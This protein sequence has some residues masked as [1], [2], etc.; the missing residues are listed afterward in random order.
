MTHITPAQARRA[1]NAIAMDTISGALCVRHVTPY[2]TLT[3]FIQ[4]YEQM[5][6]ALKPFAT[7]GKI[8]DGPFGPA[9][10]A[11]DNMAFSSGCAW[12]ENGE[13]KTLTWGNFRR[14]AA[15]TKGE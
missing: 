15:A 5:E 1:M 10:F 7:V 2:D 11:E 6:A 8:I 13:S 3:A 14:A 4:Q 9:L 12:S